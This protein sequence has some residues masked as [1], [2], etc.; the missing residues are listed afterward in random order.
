[1]ESKG[2]SRNKNDCIRN[3]KCLWW[4][5]PEIDTVEKRI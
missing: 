5:H 3:E 4:A 1:M 2:N